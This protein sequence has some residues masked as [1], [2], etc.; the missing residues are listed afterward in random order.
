MQESFVESRSQ[1][2]IVLVHVD[3]S[4]PPYPYRTVRIAFVCMACA[5][6]SRA[7]KRGNMSLSGLILN[8][9]PARTVDVKG[10]S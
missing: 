4:R 7:G 6:W 2:V 9:T 3:S 10:E 1:F 8:G 5:R